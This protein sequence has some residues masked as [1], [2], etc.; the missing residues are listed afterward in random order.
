MILRGRGRSAVAD[1]PFR[2]RESQVRDAGAGYRTQGAAPADRRGQQVR[3]RASSARPTPGDGDAG[4]DDQA[5][6][7]APARR[8]DGRRGAGS[9][10]GRQRPSTPTVVSGCE[11]LAAVRLR[12]AATAAPAVADA[13]SAPGLT[14]RPGRGPGW[15]RLSFPQHGLWD[16]RRPR[17]RRPSHMGKRTGRRSSI[18]VVP[19]PLPPHIRRFVQTT[20][21]WSGVA[22]RS[23]Y[24]PTSIVA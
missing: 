20:P 15:G 17:S 1:A 6:G 9:G 14:Q 3:V 18:C 23:V 2:P 16:P 24:W 13:P 21:A 11:R 4:G 7:R 5:D 22:L 12:S 19:T 8:G 10:F